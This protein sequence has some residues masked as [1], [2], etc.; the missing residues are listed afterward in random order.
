MF[1]VLD[2]A[3]GKTILVEDEKYSTARVS[4]GIINITVNGKPNNYSYLVDRNGERIAIRPDEQIA[5]GDFK[6]GVARCYFF[7]GTVSGP[8]LINRSGVILCQG[9]KYISWRNFSGLS[10]MIP[11]EGNSTSS[12]K[13]F[14]GFVNTLGNEI[15]PSQYFDA[16]DFHNGLALVRKK[17]DME[18]YLINSFGDELCHL[19]NLP[20]VQDHQF[21]EF[22]WKSGAFVREVG[23]AEEG[24]RQVINITGTVIYE[25]FDTQEIHALDYLYLPIAQ[26]YRI[27]F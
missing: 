18:I 2:L 6:N 27:R 13:D 17:E 3:T 10:R 21:L 16:S 22:F 19:P 5:V 1:N 24:T 15:I 8:C 9:Y 4:E 11:G 12:G 14:Y 20:K 26:Y 7:D 25:T 23:E